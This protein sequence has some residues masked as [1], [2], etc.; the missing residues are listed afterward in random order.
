MWVFQ[1]YMM[2][3]F[4]SVEEAVGGGGQNDPLTDNIFDMINKLEINVLGFS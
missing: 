4:W 1:P 3:A 2:Q